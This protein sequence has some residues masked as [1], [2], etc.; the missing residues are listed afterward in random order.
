MPKLD[1][2]I[3]DSKRIVTTPEPSTRCSPKGPRPRTHRSHHQFQEAANPFV[4]DHTIGKHAVLPTTAVISRIA[5]ACEQL[6]PDFT[7]FRVENFRA[8]KGIVFDESL[9]DEYILDLTER[10]R[11]PQAVTIEAM[12][13]H[14]GP[15]GRPRYNY[16]GTFTVRLQLPSSPGYPFRGPFTPLDGNRNCYQ[17]GTLFH[18]PLLAAV[19]KIMK[20]DPSGLV[21][22]CCSPQVTE[23]DQGQFPVYSFNPYAADVQFQAMAIWARYA[24]DYAGLPARIAAAEHFKPVPFEETYYVSLDVQSSDRKHVTA[25]I[26]QHDAQGVVYM[27]FLGTELTLNHGLNSLF[28]MG[29]KNQ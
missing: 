2:S 24:Y 15:K 11:H 1:P 10:A 28:A 13:W 29:A 16:S 27:R 14:T 3:R 21:I 19:Q 12:L 8:L 9:G 22:E 23:R 25:N 6:H 7:F 18:G 20:L 26:T 4:R 5:N 17:D